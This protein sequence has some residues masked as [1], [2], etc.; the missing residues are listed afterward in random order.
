MKC[1]VDGA[2]LMLEYRVWDG[3]EYGPDMSWDLVDD[4][5][6]EHDEDGYTIFTPKEY[7]NEVNYLMECAE[8][9]NRINRGELYEAC[10]FSDS[11]EYFGED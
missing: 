4:G 11:C 5:A 10:V 2:I 8:K 3:T 1:N 7:N 9:D 6:N